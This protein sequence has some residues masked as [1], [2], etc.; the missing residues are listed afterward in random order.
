MED[1]S[2]IKSYCLKSGVMDEQNTKSGIWG[3]WGWG[4]LMGSILLNGSV[5]RGTSQQNV[6]WERSAEGLG[7]E[8]YLSA[9]RFLET[10]C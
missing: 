10:F 1:S 7:P 3:I 4:L 9:E 8:G 6:S 2:I 5:L